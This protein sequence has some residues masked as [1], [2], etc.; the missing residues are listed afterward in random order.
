MIGTELLSKGR[1]FL[2]FFCVLVLEML[3]RP[4]PCAWL[5][6]H[7][8][9][10]YEALPLGLSGR[11]PS[12][13]LSVAKGMAVPCMEWSVSVWVNKMEVGVMPAT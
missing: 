7:T 2:W 11:C 9:H 5:L 1:T 13:F 10:Q 3:A 8:Y 12:P 4:E 6:P